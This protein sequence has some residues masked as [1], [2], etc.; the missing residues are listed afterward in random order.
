MTTRLLLPLLCAGVR[1]AFFR[2]VACPLCLLELKT[3]VPKLPQGTEAC[4]PGED[5]GP[6]SGAAIAPFA[7]LRPRSA[8][9]SDSGSDSPTSA[10]LMQCV[11]PV[12]FVVLPLLVVLYQ[13]VRF[14]ATADDS[15]WWPSQFGSSSLLGHS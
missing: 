11:R 9:T 8:E 14:V 2:S 15:G 3:R 12:F 6:E 13:L 1:G 5:V 7:K 4:L 10:Q